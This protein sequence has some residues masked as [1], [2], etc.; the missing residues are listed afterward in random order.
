MAKN[1]AYFIYNERPDSSLISSQ[2]LPLLKKIKENNPT[3]EIT[4]IAFWQ[5]WIQNKYKREIRLLK[6]ELL[7]NN[8]H[9]ENYPLA[10][11]ER[12]IFN[13]I[14][15]LKCIIRLTQIFSL[16]ILRRR[17]DLIHCR[18]YFATYINCTIKNITNGKIIFDGRSLYP[19]ENI[20]RKNW[21]FGDKIFD[22]WKKIEFYNLEKSYTSIGV[23]IPLVDALK[24]IN[25]SAK[26]NFIPCAVDIKKFQFSEIKRVEIRKTLNWGND[27]IVL[28]YS[29][30]IGLS[31]WNDIRNYISYF[32]KLKS[33]N[34]EIV[35]LILTNSDHKILKEELE[36]FLHQ[37]DFSIQNVKYS[38][39][40]NW[41]SS[42]DFGIQV[43]NETPDSFS[44]LGVKLTEY[45]ACRLP[46][47]INSYV[48]GAT[49]IVNNYNVGISLDLND[50]NF[51]FKFKNFVNEIKTNK[52]NC[53]NVANNL[54]SMEKVAK[55]YE[56]L[57]Q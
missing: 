43:M 50:A 16:F 11:P 24:R 57:Y 47:L 32:E 9:L 14:L 17:F 37:D 40:S 15:L 52:L 1:I 7:L 35:F 21:N 49:S 44:R 19:L 5:F 29:G 42:A 38:D 2:V 41:L 18:G 45:L 36:K 39:V 26:V 25:P 55:E 23:S 33:I 20:T 51:E 31:F 12:H 46:V 22:F 6:Q 53:V 3:Y 8:I 56:T 28:V 48:G 10:F 4:I 30:S 13:K 34:T 54:F 27:K